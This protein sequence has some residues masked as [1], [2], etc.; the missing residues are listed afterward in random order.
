MSEKLDAAYR[1]MAADEQREKKSLDW[2]EGL[3][4][5]VAGDRPDAAR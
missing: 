2:S 1:E 5:E 4:G 3:I